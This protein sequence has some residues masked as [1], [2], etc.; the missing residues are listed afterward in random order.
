MADVQTSESTSEDTAH[1]ARKSDLIISSAREQPKATRQTT[2]DAKSLSDKN[3]RASLKLDD[4]S[5][6]CDSVNDD[7]K[8]IDDSV[9]NI[10]GRH[11][12]SNRDMA[13]YDPSIYSIKGD[14][15]SATIAD[16]NRKH[17][18]S[19][20]SCRIESERSLVA[21][22]DDVSAN[23]NYYAV[24]SDSVAEVPTTSRISAGLVYNHN[25]KIHDRKHTC[26]RSTGSRRS[27][28][29][30]QVFES[31]DAPQGSIYKI[32]PIIIRG[33]GSFT[34]FG[35]SNSFSTDFPQALL[36]RLSREE[37]AHTMNQINLLLRN[38]QSMSAKL[39][40]FGSLFCCCSLGFT[41]V[42]PSIVLQRR[43]RC[44]M[45]KFLANENQRLYSK[46]GLNWRLG[47]RRSG[48]FTEHV[49]VIEFNPRIDLFVPD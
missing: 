13:D 9:S 48:R 17:D 34:L 33:D 15:V 5:V 44:N 32:E 6:S 10:S 49:L 1:S 22:G 19:K 38:Q 3:S 24:A 46:L 47:Q 28:T 37:F 31:Y 16:Y 8:S 39:L 42:W 25:R 40:L 12:W 45:E 2:I 23:I 36:G 18:H 35:L 20:A 7:P 29:L 14:S 4:Q 43:S 11:N 27:S 30:E 26:Q 41:L 21:K